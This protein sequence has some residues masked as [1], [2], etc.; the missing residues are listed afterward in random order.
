[1][2]NEQLTPKQKANKLVDTFRMILMN[3]NTDCGNEI[4]CTMIAIKH[5]EIC[6]DEVMELIEMIEPPYEGCA[7]GYQYFLKVR[8]ELSL[9]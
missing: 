7:K 1:M 9:L 6:V 5:S 4:L 2:D 8:H 3:E